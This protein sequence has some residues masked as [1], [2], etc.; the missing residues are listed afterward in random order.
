MRIRGA[1]AFASARAAVALVAAICDQLE[2]RFRDLR[3]EKAESMISELRPLIIDEQ[4]IVEAIHYL[5]NEERSKGDLTI[6]FQH[7]IRFERLPRL[8]EGALFRI[9]QEAL[10]NV[11]RH[12][13]STEASV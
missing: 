10:T 12:S 6:D 13:Q 1:G 7:D 4:G 5:I 9:V 8:L 3:Q 2:H 11:R